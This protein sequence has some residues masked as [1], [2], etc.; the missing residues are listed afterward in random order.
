MTDSSARM[1]AMTIALRTALESRRGYPTDGISHARHWIP[2][3]TGAYVGV[4]D[5]W[6]V[7]RAALK[8]AECPDGLDVELL[9]AAFIEGLAVMWGEPS[10]AVSAQVR[11]IFVRDVIARYAALSA[12]RSTPEAQ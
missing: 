7:V 3:P 9:Y 5:A 10:D 8:D 1:H 2:D 12:L 11:P 4:D 6:D